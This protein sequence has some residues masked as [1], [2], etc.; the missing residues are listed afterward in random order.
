MRRQTDRRNAFKAGAAVEQAR[1]RRSLAAAAGLAMLLLLA[2]TAWPTTWPTACA[3]R[4]VPPQPLETQQVRLPETLGGNARPINAGFRATLNVTCPF[5]VGY[6]GV[7]IQLDSTTGPLAAERPLVIRFTPTERHIPADR[8]M[9]ATLPIVFHQGQTRA[10]LERQF[11]K[12]TVGDTYRIEILENGSPLAGYETE[13]GT[14][15]PA[16]ATQS[17]VSL[18]AQEVIHKVLYVGTAPQMRS[19]P[20]EEAFLGEPQQRFWSQVRPE[21]LPTDWRLLREIDSIVINHADLVSETARRDDS[22]PDSSEQTA[23]ANPVSPQTGSEGERSR[24]RS[25]L[26]D[27]VLSGGTL[28][29]VGVENADQ[30]GETLQFSLTTAVST[31]VSLQNIIQAKHDQTDERLTRYRDWIRSAERQMSSNATNSGLPRSIAGQL[32]GNAMANMSG[33]SMSGRSVGLYGLTPSTQQIRQAKKLVAVMDQE[34]VD[35]ANSWGQGFWCTVGAGSVVGLGETGMNSDFDLELLGELAGYRR[36]AMLKRGV[37]P[38]LGDRRTQRWLIPGVA[39]PPVYTFIGILTLFVLLVGPV[40]YRWTTRG[41][42]S[43]LM[44]LIAPI[45]ALLTTVAMFTYSIVADGFRTTA[46]IRQLTWIDGA[47]G[48]AFERTRSTLFAGISPNEGVSFDA[49][50][51]VMSYPDDPR[52]HWGNLPNAVSEVRARVRVDDQRQSFD[53]SLLPSRTQTQFVAHRLRHQLGRIAWGKAPEPLPEKVDSQADVPVDSPG[54]E[55]PPNELETDLTDS[56]ATDAESKIPSNAE[57]TF[58]SSLPF[59]VR[60]L[61]A[62]SSDGRYWIADSIPAEGTTSARWVADRR[63]ASKQLGSLYNRFRPIGAVYES[64]NSGNSSEVR[65]LILFHNRRI[66]RSRPPVLTGTL[67]DWLNEY[68]FV[69]GELPE[70]TYVG[71]ATPSQDVL[72]IGDADV[73]ESVRYVIGT[74]P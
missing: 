39:E 45:L 48:D 43:H 36:S 14:P 8:C 24:L 47:S 23:S 61:I 59:P 6:V 71:I 13:I 69:R 67:E 66:S 29:V 4:F 37:D 65:D 7:R 1:Q 40:S 11:P 56:D 3:A 31:E 60:D 46:R 72:A 34:N 44:F 20:L 68:L 57:V 50:A 21:A 33:T 62:R 38:I 25:T 19:D 70:G 30:L 58:V 22:A 73:V 16:F 15:L 28:V 74:L 32:E 64:R 52:R 18:L 42:R 49:A 10:L 51:E 41:H 63:L 2:P 5:N 17:P 26:R 27:W 54:A 35:F 53:R 55:A 12:W 9:V